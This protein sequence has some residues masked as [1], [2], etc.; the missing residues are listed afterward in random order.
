[1]A[2]AV[3]ADV[4]AVVVAATVAVVPPPRAAGVAVARAVDL[5]VG[6]P[7]VTAI[8]PGSL[9]V[10]NLVAMATAPSVAVVIGRLVTIDSLEAVS[11][12]TATAMVVRNVK[13][14]RVITQ[15]TAATVRL[16]LALTINGSSMVAM[17]VQAS[18][19]ADSV[20][21]VPLDSVIAQAVVVPAGAGN[22]SQAPSLV[23]RPRHA[24]SA[25]PQCSSKRCSPSLSRG[26]SRPG[27]S[28]VSF[29]C[30]T[31]VTHQTPLV[32]SCDPRA[33][34]IAVSAWIPV[35]GSAGRCVAG[36]DADANVD[37]YGNCL[38]HNG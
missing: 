12:N 35:A 2:E 29:S 6:I 17:A 32:A 33:A 23:L 30:E 13:R 16:A 26:M 18:S 25:E 38:R 5:A 19:P 15:P 37:T 7:A 24:A 11:T 22:G 1:M 3:V 20:A 8:V 31:L 27:R 28:G 36:D 9:A 10:D 34:G 21:A 4:M 14:V